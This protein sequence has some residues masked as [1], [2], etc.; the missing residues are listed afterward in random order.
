MI[1]ASENSLVVNHTIAI[2]AESIEIVKERMTH[3][4]NLSTKV[5]LDEL[6]QIHA[7]GAH[8]SAQFA[9]FHLQWRYSLLTCNYP[10]AA[11]QLHGLMTLHPESGMA[12]KWKRRR[13]WEKPFP[14]HLPRGRYSHESLLCV[15]SL[16]TTDQNR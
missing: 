11:I 12:L 3:N 13:K 14:E 15:K 5:T 7:L 2:C 1:D 6:R 4:F 8:N 9:E 16:S 10:Q